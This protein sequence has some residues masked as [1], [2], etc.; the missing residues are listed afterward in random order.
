MQGMVRR[1][2]IP[3]AEGPAGR[4][5]A[6]F[7]GKAQRTRQG[8]RAFYQALGGGQA[9]AEAAIARWQELSRKLHGQAWPGPKVRLDVLA[10]H[11]A[12]PAEGLRPEALLLALESWYA[13]LVR[14]FMGE[15]LAAV[16]PGPSPAQRLLGAE[17]GPGLRKEIESLFGGQS[18][19]ERS[20]CLGCEPWLAWYA[21]ACPE[22]V[23]Q[24]IR[25]LAAPLLH[26]DA[27]WWLE[28]GKEGRDLL[29]PLYQDLFPRVLRHSLGE[30]YTPDWLA[31][32]VLD[33]AGYCG[34]AGTRLLDPACGSGTFLVAA[35]RRL[36]KTGC[37]RGEI[38]KSIVGLDLHPL[39]AMTARANYLLAIVD[40]LAEAEPPE[41]PVY[42]CDAILDG[43]GPGV[44][45]DGFDYVVGNPPWIAWDNLP[46]DYRVATRPLWQGYG[47]FSLSAREARHGG[48]KKDLA[49]L[50]LYVSA[51]R[52]LRRGGRLG[53][54]V[55]QTA[56][57]T[58]GAGDGF[59]RFRLGPDGDWLGVLRVDDLVAVRPFGDASN[60][61]STIVLEKGRATQYP[62]PYV[63]WLSATERQACL[64][65][66]IAADRPGSPWLVWPA[67]SVGWVDGHHVRMVGEARQ[68][69][70]NPF[71]VGLADQRC[72]SV[73]VDPPNNST[74]IYAETHHDPPDPFHRGTARL[75]VLRRDRGRRRTC[76]HLGP[77][78][79]RRFRADRLG[80]GP[81]EHRRGTHVAGGRAGAGRQD[82]QEPEDRRTLRRQRLCV[83]FGSARRAALDSR[84]RQER[85][86]AL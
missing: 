3:S 23:Q 32:H 46:P 13:V 69:R 84:R 79:G 54:V 24:A 14:L 81:V 65:R 68:P 7:G 43:P 76:K 27:A 60:W 4:L 8:V 21:A 55:T 16:G 12:V 35:I 72:A 56:F 73:P 53:M 20:G 82:G 41:I 9:A 80:A 59:R 29:K 11:Y 48:G 47:L 86:A 61:S 34:Q 17:A 28:R 57:Q 83:F 51:D 36:R 78:G 18:S 75:A 62:V 38:V 1:H 63:K 50:M 85:D 19:R 58:K 40:L 33:Q 26:Y 70:F 25:S 31:E 49:M 15:M 22:A 77:Q 44:V 67:T 2:K 5:L 37:N 6:D 39:A 66:P 45:A 64:A 42:T 10:A 30:Y 71:P 74:N 52:Y